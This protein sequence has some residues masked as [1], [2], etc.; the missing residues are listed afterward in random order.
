[1]TTIEPG[2]RMMTT[3][4]LRR[5]KEIDPYY[6]TTFVYLIGNKDLGFYKIGIAQNVQKRAAS[7]SLPFTVEVFHSFSRPDRGSALT[8][9]QELHRLYA[10]DN[11]LGEWFRDIDL[12]QFPYDAEY[13]DGNRFDLA[14][15]AYFKRKGI[16]SPKPFSNRGV[17]SSTEKDRRVLL[18]LKEDGIEAAKIARTELGA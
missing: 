13:I 4:R 6:R 9:E 2:Y 5:L 11:L 10:P 8:M 1:M 18:I 14:Q 17:V 12:V 7:L 16:I 15:A 3:A